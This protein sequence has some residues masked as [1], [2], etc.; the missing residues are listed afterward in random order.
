MIIE[1]LRNILILIAIVATGIVIN[2]VFISKDSVCPADFK[3]SEE[4]TMAFEKWVDNFYNKNPEAT[5]SEISKARVYFWIDNNCKEALKTYADYMSEQINEEEE[6]P[7][8]LVIT[9]GKIKTHCPEDFETPEEKSASSREWTEAFIG[10]NPDASIEEMSNAR[11]NFLIDNNCKETLAE[12]NYPTISEEKLKEEFLKEIM[13]EI[14]E[15]Q[16]SLNF[17]F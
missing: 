12:Y 14:L 17:D 11:V 5:I 6:Q 9:E 3:T 4:K 7:R 16:K 8:E 1:Q 15:S 10:D 13:K 2:V